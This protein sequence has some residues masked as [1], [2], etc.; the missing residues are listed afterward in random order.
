ITI[1]WKIVRSE[2]LISHLGLSSRRLYHLSY[3][4]PRLDRSSYQ[5]PA[6]NRSPFS[7]YSPSSSPKSLNLQS[8]LLLRRMLGLKS[9]LLE[10]F[11]VRLL[12]YD[13][14]RFGESDPHPKRNL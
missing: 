14:P 6:F 1:K 3:S 4:S 5:L 2:V 9:S 10:E 13:L 12:T 7:I 8:S 11:E